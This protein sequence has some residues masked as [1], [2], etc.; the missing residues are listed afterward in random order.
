MKKNIVKISTLICLTSALIC[1]DPKK[2]DPTENAAFIQEREKILTSK[3]WVNEDVINPTTKVSLPISI[4][5]TSEFRKYT[6]EGNNN[7][8]IITN[9]YYSFYNSTLNG[10][11]GLRNNGETLNMTV[12]QGNSRSESNYKIVKLI[13]DSLIIESTIETPDTIKGVVW[14][15]FI[16]FTSKSYNE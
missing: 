16:D 13:S 8:R 10:T 15:R 9:S 5:F 11:W 7:L 6:F 12:V 14:Y 1:C 4:P 3:V 2:D